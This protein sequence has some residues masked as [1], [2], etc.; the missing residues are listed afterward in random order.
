MFESAALCCGI[1]GTTACLPAVALAEAGAVVDFDA[2]AGKP[3][4][5]ER[6]PRNATVIRNEQQHVRR[7]NH[8]RRTGRQH[9]RGAAR[10]RRTPRGSLRARKGSAVYHGLSAVVV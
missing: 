2:M 3:S 5:L 4:F 1:Q 8:W 9:G 7:R 6:G 10:A